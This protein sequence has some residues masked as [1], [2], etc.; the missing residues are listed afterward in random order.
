MLRLEDRTLAEAKPAMNPERR[1]SMTI[2]SRGGTVFNF[3]N[4]T[5][6]QVVHHMTEAEPYGFKMILLEEVECGSS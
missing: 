1:F 5:F 6:D 2:K 3:E 4:L